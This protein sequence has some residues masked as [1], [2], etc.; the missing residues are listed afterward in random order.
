VSRAGFEGGDRGLTLEHN[1]MV[2]RLGYSDEHMSLSQ[3]Q[4]ALNSCLQA[5]LATWL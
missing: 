2:V 5:V 3:T 4:I 1:D